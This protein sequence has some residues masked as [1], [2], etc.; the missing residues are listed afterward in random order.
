MIGVA[1]SHPSLE[2]VIGLGAI[3]VVGEIGPKTAQALFT[4]TAED[5]EKSLNASEE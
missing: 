3:F 4:F 1:K 2:Q 5:I